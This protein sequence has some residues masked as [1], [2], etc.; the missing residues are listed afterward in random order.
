MRRLLRGLP[1]A[2]VLL[3]GTVMYANETLRLSCSQRCE[4]RYQS[5]VSAARSKYAVCVR[6]GFARFDQCQAM[7]QGELAE[8]ESARETCL[9]NC[10]AQ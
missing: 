2:A 7:L 6:S 4:R 1:F 9:Q 3:A 5:A 10:K 8:A